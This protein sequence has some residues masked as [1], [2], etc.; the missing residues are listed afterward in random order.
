MLGMARM[1]ASL[2]QFVH[3][4]R[5]AGKAGGGID[6]LTAVQVREQAGLSAEELTARFTAVGPRAM[7]FRRRM[8]R[9]VGRIRLP[10]E[11]VV[12]SRGESWTIGFLMDVVL[13]R[14]TWLHR[15][16]ICRAT[17]REMELTAEHDGVLVADV[18]AE[19]AQRHGRPHELY[20]TGPAGGRWSAGTGGPSLELDAVEFCRVLSGRGTV[21]GLLAE[22]VPF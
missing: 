20:L 15:V 18:V 8:S 21:A 2:P 4:L 1:N 5:A 16:D 22:Q 7:R 17:G 6:A 3:Q 14:D 19:W 12:G 10:E 11:Q 9:V 13:T